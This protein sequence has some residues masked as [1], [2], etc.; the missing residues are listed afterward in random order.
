MVDLT[1]P[2]MNGIDFFRQLRKHGRNLPVL[3]CSGYARDAIPSDL[4]K[5]QLVGFIQ[6][7][8]KSNVLKQEIARLLVNT[9]R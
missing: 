6:K 2:K 3:F 1:M 5:D 4:Y 7:P 8:Y 9:S